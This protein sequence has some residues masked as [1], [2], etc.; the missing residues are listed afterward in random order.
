MQRFNSN[1]LGRCLESGG[2][3]PQCYCCVAIGS[4]DRTLSVWCTALKRPLVV[5]H[6]LFTDSVLDL[7]WST[8][9]EFNVTHSI[10]IIYQDIHIII[11][12]LS[13]FE[14]F[15]VQLGRHSC[16]YSIYQRRNRSAFIDSRKSMNIY[17]CKCNI[18]K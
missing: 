13:R 10:I 4:R 12:I 17:V 6:E 15:G 11:Q 9:G 7:S 16:I 5:I 3:G 14:S 1:I 2:R 8:D 18:L